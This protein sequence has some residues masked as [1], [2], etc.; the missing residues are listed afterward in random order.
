MVPLRT[1]SSLVSDVVNDKDSITRILGSKELHDLEV[2]LINLAFK[3]ETTYQMVTTVYS[4]PS[5]ARLAR[6]GS[7]LGKKH[8][9]K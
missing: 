4:E 6:R 1:S 7:I 2:I 8:M 5:T 3:N 9:V